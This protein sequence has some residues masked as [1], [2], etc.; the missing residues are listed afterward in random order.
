MRYSELFETKSSPCIVVDVQPEYTGINDG[1]ELPWIDDMMQFLNRQTGPILMFVNAEN[2][3]LTADT[4]ADIREYWSDSG[5][6]DWDRVTIVDKGYGYFRGWMDGGIPEKF[7][8]ATIRLMYQQRVDDSRELFGGEDSDTYREEFAR[9]F[10]HND[11]PFEEGVLS[12]PLSI[13][14]TSVSQLKKFGGGYIMGGGRNECL[15]EVELLLNA[16]N[17]RARRINDFIYGY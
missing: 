5:F 13:N 11:V 12:D 4:V 14:W 8:I 7:I 3:G 16:F 2:D 17:I 10:A 1:S 6:T 9:W 15:R